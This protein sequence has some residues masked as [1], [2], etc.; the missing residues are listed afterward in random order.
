MARTATVPVALLALIAL[1]AS[2]APAVQPGEKWLY[3]SAPREFKSALVVLEV[4]SHQSCGPLALVE[5]LEADGSGAVR[6]WLSVSS[7]Q[8][9]VTERL[10]SGL[11]VDPPRS[12][13]TWG[14]VEWPAIPPA[15]CPVTSTVPDALRIRKALRKGSQPN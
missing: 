4:R 3:R 11:Q 6:A 14:S 15:Q 2:G 7:L 5:V 9:S 8:A 12:S 10:A 1:A 13:F